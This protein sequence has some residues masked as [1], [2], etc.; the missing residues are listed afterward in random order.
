LVRDYTTKL[1]QAY[2]QVAASFTIHSVFRKAGLIPEFKSRLLR[3]HFNEDVLRAN[4]GFS[5]IWN[6]NIS[7]D[8]L[9]K[10]RQL[11]Q[12]GLINADFSARN[13]DE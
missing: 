8:Q 11:Y 3:P 5:E 6:F 9:S 2:E 13:R 1:L 4:P 10:R 7:L 12:F